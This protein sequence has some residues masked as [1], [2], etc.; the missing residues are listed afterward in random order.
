MSKTAIK[1]QNLPE[2]LVWYYIIGTYVIYYLGAQYLF[3]PLLGAFL[4]IYTFVRLWRQNEQTPLQE[5][6][7]VPFVSWLW[8]VAM[9]V[10]EFSLIMGHLHFDL[11]VDQIV[12]STMNRWI[13]TWFLF[14]MFLIAGSLHI[15]PQLI[16]RAVCI[17]GCG[18]DC[19]G[20]S[21]YP[22]IYLAFKSVWWR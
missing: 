14:P 15:R 6:V 18:W 17:P 8:L 1:P 20:Y 5:R 11:G 19:S 9:L 2:T 4:M 16:Y 7:A 3:A 21:R 10:I 22:T 12:K 13:R